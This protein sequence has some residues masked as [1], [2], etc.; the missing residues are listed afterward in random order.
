MQIVL[1]IMLFSIKI[2]KKKHKRHENY[3]ITNLLC[4]IVIKLYAIQFCLCSIRCYCA[5]FIHSKRTILIPI[6]F[7][8]RYPCIY[9]SLFWLNIETIKIQICFGVFKIVVRTKLY[10]LIIFKVKIIVIILSLQMC[11]YVCGAY[12]NSLKSN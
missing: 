5:S 11:V 10:I 2:A 7:V 6:A 12:T 9:V 8:Y 3:S 1:L 4:S